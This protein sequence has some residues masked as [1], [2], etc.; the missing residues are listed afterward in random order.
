MAL[1][2]GEFKYFLKVLGLSYIEQEFC[3]QR[4]RKHKPNLLNDKISYFPV[5]SHLTAVFK[6][7]ETQAS[8]MKHESG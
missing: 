6:G 8:C 7:V 1:T 3:T 2:L 5:P 4:S